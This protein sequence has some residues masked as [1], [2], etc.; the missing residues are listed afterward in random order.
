MNVFPLNIVAEDIGLAAEKGNENIDR[1][2]CEN[3]SY[4]R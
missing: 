1:K 2:Y 4:E 3:L